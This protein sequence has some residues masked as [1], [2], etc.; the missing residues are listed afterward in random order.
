MADD[1]TMLG[2]FKSRGKRKDDLDDASEGYDYRHQAIIF[3]IEMSREAGV[4]E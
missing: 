3:L 2:I 1:T 4:T